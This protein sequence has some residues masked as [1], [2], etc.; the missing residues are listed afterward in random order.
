MQLIFKIYLI[1]IFLTC[2]P[3]LGQRQV[4][5]DAYNGKIAYTGAII[6]TG[7][8]Q[9]LEN[10]T[11]VIE[12]GSIIAI[13]QNIPTQDAKVIDVTDQHIYPGFISVNNTTGLV[14]NE[15]VKAT[16]DFNESADMMPEVRTLIAYN[17]DS[18][19]IPTIRTNGVL[20]TQP[21]LKSGILS[22]TSS[23]MRL[24]G[25][26]WE[27]AVEKKDNVLHLNWPDNRLIADEKRREDFQKD[28]RKKLNAVQDLFI[29]ARQYEEKTNYKDY[30]LEAIKP[31]FSGE[32]I[33][34]INLR[35]ADETLE[36]IQWAKSLTLPK[37]VLIVNHSVLGV[38]NE[39]KNAGY[40]LIVRRIH[41]LPA[42]TDYTPNASFEFPAILQ[43]HGILFGLDY[44]GDME[45][46]GVRNLP[47][48]AGTAI[49]HGLEYEAA[50]QSISYNLA[51]ILGIEDRIGSLEVGKQA[52]FFIS[53]DDALDQLT[54]QVTHAVIKGRPIDLNNKQ[55]DL[56]KTYHQKY[57]GNDSIPPTLEHLQ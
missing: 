48:L 6:H 25:W 20:F 41:D 31:V 24:D 5:Q 51:K 28:R 18:H 42:T 1:S 15:A 39:I 16:V 27:D 17:T 7:T 19:I 38:I 57:F 32:K 33:L 46:M 40:P 8:G 56:Y 12:G 21:T 26:N 55:N 52:T 49:A 22:G 43:S 14:E 53:K 54:N 3:L 13:G 37:V 44:S 11:I 30:K 10:A 23:V 35:G 29:R 45:Y 2:T 9:K 50:V 34:F 47:F 4:P 36:A